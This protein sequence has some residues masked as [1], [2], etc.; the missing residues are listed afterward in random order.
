MSNFARSNFLTGAAVADAQM[1]GWATLPPVR[2]A[3]GKIAAYASMV[4]RRVADAPQR[5]TSGR[6]GS[7]SDRRIG[8]TASR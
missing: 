6:H 2:G 1:N 3:Q 5:A 7:V 4:H 8:Y